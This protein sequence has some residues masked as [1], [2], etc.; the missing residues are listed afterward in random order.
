MFPRDSTILTAVSPDGSTLT[1]LQKGIHYEIRMNGRILMTSENT[2]SEIRLAEIAVREMDK[3]KSPRILI[4]GLGMGFTLK[5]VLQLL[6]RKAY[7]KVI[8]ICPEIVTWNQG[9]LSSLNGGALEDLRTEFII[10]D[11]FEFLTD[12]EEK[13]HR[14]IL[15]VDNGPEFLSMKKNS[16]LYR[17]KGLE[18]LKTCLIS[19][20]SLSLWSS[21]PS[22][23]LEKNLQQ[24]GFSVC[25][26]NYSLANGNAARE[27][28]LY[29]AC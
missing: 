10:C 18:R 21:E 24:T 20:G 27:Y 19:G 4:G 1:L 29:L 3:V 13:F 12:N 17:P 11:I 15:D 22:P 26:E 14:I 28:Y 9:E 6:P 25:V 5:R 23:A 8:E 7:V 2:G 16:R